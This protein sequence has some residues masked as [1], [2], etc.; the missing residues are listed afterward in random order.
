MAVSTKNSKVGLGDPMS[1]GVQAAYFYGAAVRGGKADW[2]LYKVVQ[3]SS[4]D[5]WYWDDDDAGPAPELMESGQAELDEDGRAAVGPFPASE[6]GVWR[7]VVKVADSSGQQNSGSVQVR[8]AKGDMVLFVGADRGVAVPGKPFQVQAKAL[9]L[10]GNE[11]KSVPITLKATRIVAEKKST[12]WWAQPSA[13]RPGEVVASA[14]GPKAQLTIPEGGMFL[15]LAEAK[16]RKGRLVTAQ[17]L[18]TVAA[19]GTPLP[20]VPDLRAVSDKRDY[21]PGETARIL[22]RLPRPKLTLHWSLEHER[23]GQRQSRLVQGTTTVVE[24]PVT[25]DMQP[26]VWA[27]F[28]IVA[29]GSRQLAEVPIRVPRL[30]RRLQVEIAM[31]R[32]RYQPGQTMKLEVRVKDHDGRPVAADLSMGVVDEAIYALSAELNP[33]PVRFFHPTRRHSV[34]RSGSTDWSFYDLLHRQRP[35]WSLKQTRRGDFKNDDSD[36]VRQNFKDT[37]LWVPFLAAGA[38]GRASAE[39]VLPDNLTAWRATAT[40]VTADTK[41]GV[42]R[43]ARPSS[44]PL[45]VSLTLPRTLTVGDEARAIAQVRNLSGGPL[46]GKVRIEVGNGTLTGNPETSFSVADQ[47]EFRLALPLVPGGTGTLTVTA[48]VEAG[49][50]KDAERRSV[51]VLD[52]LIPASVSGCIVLQGGT[53]RVDIPAPPKAKGEA[54]LVLAPVGSL[55]HLAAPSLPYLVNYPYGCV[56][57]TLSSFVPN[58]LLADLVKQGLMPPIDWKTLVDLDRNIRDG[59]FR[60]YGYQQHDGG[61]GWYAPHDF[62]EDANPH[63]TGYALQSFATMQ[64]LGYAVDESSYRRGRQ[65][66]VYLFQEAAKQADERVPGTKPEK[67]QAPDPWADSAF[68]LQALAQTGEPLAGILD[69]TAD[70]VLAG[71]WP[72][73]HVLAMTAFA[74]AR[75]RH[76]RTQALVA[77]LEQTAIV[78]GGLARWEGNRDDWYGYS[79]GEVFPTAMALKALA[80]ARPRSPLIPQAEAFLAAQFQG[81]G[82]DST[83]TTAQVVEVLPYLAKV[84]KLDWKAP[85]LKAAVEGGPAWDFS[86]KEDRT[87]RRWGSREPRPG[88]FAMNEPRS[89]Q[90]TALGQGMLVWTYAYQVPGS[91]AAAPKAE[92]SSALRMDLHRAIWRLKTP[93]QTGDPRKGWIREKWTGAMRVGDEAWLELQA[94]ASRSADY[95]ILEVPIPAGLTPTVN[96][97]GF[98]LEGKAFTEDDGAE[99]WSHKPRIEVRADKVVFFFQ[100]L[101]PWEAPKVR[102]LLR[103]AMA[104]RYRFRPA[105]LSLMSSESQWTTCDGLDLA[106]QEGGH[107]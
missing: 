60:V 26:N 34:Q 17:R 22:V 39:V 15:L 23:L 19:E 80:L 97:E 1:F 106:V 100:R 43:T 95:A 37:A 12:S 30:D 4:P 74:A 32:D 72:G 53:K 52:P 88:Y 20:A 98:V 89:V 27:V 94:E 105:K 76:P 70:K 87:F 55:E 24:I 46:S 75:T 3:R 14:P 33:D 57:Q 61:W 54:S 65:A 7:L 69:S 91:A 59:V 86:G 58:V 103:A 107:P 102:I 45:Q 81:F 28:E 62:G 51:T 73:G 47:G 16:D 9:D 31:D 83:W 64:R 71:K 8:A 13:L 99:T 96:L 29:E 50:L 44:K 2:F 48:R 36:K 68:L 40:A 21:R 77:R 11:L 5:G 38:D 18:I 63:T 92:S 90:V 67:G 41:V 93:Q 42:G 82:W 79:S 49:G 84:R 35:V 6:E 56:E 25:A 101:L 66:A 85:S 10:D 78:K 104:G